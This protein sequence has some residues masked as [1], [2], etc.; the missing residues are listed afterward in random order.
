MWIVVFQ[1]TVYIF[2]KEFDKRLQQI[3][4]KTC[5]FKRFFTLNVLLFLS[6]SFRPQCSSSYWVSRGW[7]NLSDF[8]SLQNIKNWKLW[9]QEDKAQNWIWAGHMSKPFELN[10]ATSLS[11]NTWHT[12]SVLFFKRRSANED[13]SRTKF[14]V[15]LSA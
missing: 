9:Q 5:I 6:T 11:N 8:C 14:L 1:N 4:T 7:G 12:S 2:S 3:S 13:M 15:F 10:T